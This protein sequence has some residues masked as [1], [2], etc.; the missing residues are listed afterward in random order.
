MFLGIMKYFK[1]SSKLTMFYEILNKS[2]S[3][4]SLFLTLFIIILTGYALI[5]HML[6]GNTDPNFN[7][8]GNS[9]ISLFMMVVGSLCSF[10]IVSYYTEI[11]CLYGATYMFFGIML[12][13]MFVAIIGSHYFEYYIEQDY[14]GSNFFKQLIKS[15]VG[16]EK[17]IALNESQGF[18]KRIYNQIINYL[19]KW[20]Y[21]FVI[22]EENFEIKSRYVLPNYAENKKSIQ[23]HASPIILKFIETNYDEN[24]FMEK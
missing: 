12:L 5:G 24:K 13:N 3:D 11:K 18:A 16:S 21:D 22:I 15:Y 9:L 1:F 23:L 4:I 14:V 8:L 10:D 17:D 20:A 19:R 7:T 2:F 6:F